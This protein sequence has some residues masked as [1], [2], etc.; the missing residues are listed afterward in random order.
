MLLQCWVSTLPGTSLHVC[1]CTVQRLSTLFKLEVDGLCVPDLVPLLYV[2]RAC[3][4]PCSS[5]GSSSLLVPQAPSRTQRSA[6]TTAGRASQ[7]ELAAGRGVG[8]CLWAGPAWLQGPRR[9][10]STA[11][12][13]R[14]RRACRAAGAIL[15]HVSVCSQLHTARLA[16]WMRRHTLVVVHAVVWRAAP[17]V[18]HA[19]QLCLDT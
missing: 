11:V 8:R 18:Q 4:C 2:A 12:A 6:E 17:Q 13:L 15:G 3:S 16:A 14:A 1:S 10:E 5:S 19:L 7:V 9:Q